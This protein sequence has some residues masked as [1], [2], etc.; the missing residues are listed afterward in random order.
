M[1]PKSSRAP[2]SR[3]FARHGWSMRSLVTATRVRRLRLAGAGRASA[4]VRK[5]VQETACL[6]Q[7][8]PLIART[9]QQSARAIAVLR[10]VAVPQIA[11]PGERTLR[12]THS[13]RAPGTIGRAGARKVGAS[14]R[15]LVARGAASGTTWGR[16]NPP[17][18]VGSGWQSVSAGGRGVRFGEDAP[19]RAALM[20]EPAV[21]KHAPSNFPKREVLGCMLGH[22]DRNFPDEEVS[23]CMP[24]RPSLV[25]N[26]ARAAGS[27]R[28]GR[29]RLASA[30]VRIP[31]ARAGRASPGGGSESHGPSKI[32]KAD[33]RGGMA[34]HALPKIRV[35]DLLDGMGWSE[36]RVSPGGVGSGGAPGRGE[37]CGV[38]AR[39]LAARPHV[40]VARC[41]ESGS[42]WGRMNHPGGVGSRGAP[43]RGEACGVSARK[44]AARPRVVVA[45]GATSGSKCRGHASARKWVAPECLVAS[46]AT[47]GS[48]L[49]RLSAKAELPWE[50]AKR[51]QVRGTARVARCARAPTPR[52]GVRGHPRAQPRSGEHAGLTGVL[53]LRGH[54]HQQ[55]FEFFEGAG[56][57]SRSGSLF[58]V[59][60][61]LF[62]SISSAGAKGGADV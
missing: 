14:E 4:G 27:L 56:D 22:G 20:G 3:G 31:V 35:L 57:R 7:S 59:P 5:K 38:S 52:S 50:P 8:V 16:M 34:G 41:A 13:A 37:V 23:G 42:K 2:R 36:V 60:G 21:Q 19:Q 33:L 43:G 28:A 6:G 44:L 10:G 45:L 39:T 9:R 17:G 62:H 47:S 55:A 26:F 58:L 53:R 46:G 25:A 1:R 40:V 11:R 12:R 29:F 54:L 30:S 18:G 48:K 61:S 32:Q 49:S 15:S 51:T 24:R